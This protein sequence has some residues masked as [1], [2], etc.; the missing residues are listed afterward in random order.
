MNEN[1]PPQL[2]NG[3]RII[4]VSIFSN[5]QVSPFPINVTGLYRGMKMHKKDKNMKTKFRGTS[6]KVFNE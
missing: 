2:L 4:Y 6:T 3:I 5:I 1:A